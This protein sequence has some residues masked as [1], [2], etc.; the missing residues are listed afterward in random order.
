MEKTKVILDVDTGSDDAI[1]IMMAV[2]HPDLEVLGITTVNGNQPVP[3]TTENTLRVVDLLGVGDKVPVY[4]GCEEPMVAELIPER[5]AESRQAPTKKIV[6]GELITYHREYLDVIPPSVTKEQEK[7]AVMYLVDTLMNSDGDIT[8]IP[9][10]PLTNIAVAMRAEPRI[11]EKIKKIVIMGGGHNKSNRTSSAEFNIW[12][13]PEAA[14]IVLTSG[15]DILM[16]PLDATHEGDVTA[17]E[18][19]EIREFGS[20]VARAVADLLDQRIKAYDM[21]Q[22][23]KIA[24]STPPHDALAVA[25][26]IDPDVLQDVQWRRVDVDFSGGICDGR[27]M[28]DCRVYPDNPPNIHFAFGCDRE[29]F[30]KLLKETIKLAGNS[31]TK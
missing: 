12:K 17:E 25:A 3:N 8:L 13:D 16:V 24:G 20:P 18:S 6:E 27:T 26:V 21:F 28:V 9:V 30:V 2:L 23:Q 10:G 5:H 15:C 22:P 19:Q 29:R 11:K 4:R 31:C 7:S 1:A 14:Q